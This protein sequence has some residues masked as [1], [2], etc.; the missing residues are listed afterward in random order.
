MVKLIIICSLLFMLSILPGF[1]DAGDIYSN[2]NIEDPYTFSVHGVQWNTGGDMDGEVM[3]D[4]TIDDDSLDLTDITLADFTD[5]INNTVDS[6]WNTEA[7][8]EAIWAASQIYTSGDDFSNWVLEYMLDCLN[9][10][11]DNY[12]LTY[13]SA[14]GRFNWEEQ[15]GASGATTALDNLASVAINESLVSDTDNTD[16]VGSS[17]KGWRHFYASD[18]NTTAPST[19]GQF[20]Y[21]GNRFEFYQAGAITTTMLLG[22]AAGDMIYQVDTVEEEFTTITE[23][24]INECLGDDPSNGWN[25]KVVGSFQADNGRNIKG[26][27]VHIG[28]QETPGE[29]TVRIETDSGGHASGT[30]AHANLTGTIAEADIG[31]ANAWV[32]CTFTN[33]GYLSASTTYWLVLSLA[34]D[35]GANELYYISGDADDTYANGHY[36]YHPYGGSWTNGTEIVDMAF[37]IEYAD[38]G[39]LSVGSDNDV[40]MV[41]GDYPQWEAILDEDDMASDSATKL[42]TQQSIKKY[43]DDSV[44]TV[45]SITYENSTDV[46]SGANSPTSWTDLSC[47][48]VV[49]ANEALVMIRLKSGTDMN[50]ISVRRNGDTNEYYDE[51][52]DP[53]AY[54]AVFGHH[55]AGADIMLGPIMTDSAGK[56]EW[57]TQSAQAAN[58]YVVWW[59]K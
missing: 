15:A 28:K 29:V 14:S 20:N 11:V 13:D 38:W 3:G 25:D 18:A 5:D 43:V 47:A 17:A 34:S 2:T 58:V 7:E 50:E 59:I 8:V 24:T 23:L 26:I 33:A 54:G 36:E 46:N 39:I 6:E 16:D 37:K 12:V 9:A 31:A 22:V 30:L 40:L 48:G 45:M 44:P 56:I 42:A 35:P 49:G 53:N 55:D 51:G 19:N 1:G 41:D 32:A 21:A 10:A 27:Q 52:A 57:I 4:D